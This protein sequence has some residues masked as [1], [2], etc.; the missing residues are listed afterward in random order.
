MIRILLVLALVAYLARALAP[1]LPSWRSR[2]EHGAV[3]G[4]GVALHAAGLAGEIFLEGWQQT[5]HLTL[6]GLALTV[7]LSHLY[8]RR[9][10]RMSR[11]L[12]P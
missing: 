9:H 12:R 6:E 3:L 8:L 2:L 10:P 4:M 5:L 11:T 7:I 1:W